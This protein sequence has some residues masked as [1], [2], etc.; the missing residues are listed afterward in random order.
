MGLDHNIEMLADLWGEAPERI[1]H[2]VLLPLA[3]FTS[4]TFARISTQEYMQDGPKTFGRP[5]PPRPQGLGGPIQKLSLRLSRAVEGQFTHAGG[6]S[7]KREGEHIYEL[8]G[9]GLIW[10]AKIEDVPYAAIQE[11]GGKI[12]TSSDME[13]FFWAKY[14]EAIEEGYIGE[15]FV[16]KRLALAAKV[17]SHFV[18][19]ARPYMQPAI[20]DSIQLVA[21]RGEDL[22]RTLL[23]NI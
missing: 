7:G 6:A 13:A 4:I 20:E 23:N 14:Y 17:K 12:K 16:W 10:T 19:P 2:E 9:E 8:T 5:S 11:V 22:L 15:E 1:K 3:R 21:D 18:I